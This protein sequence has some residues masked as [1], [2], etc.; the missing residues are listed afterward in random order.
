MARICRILISNFLMTFLRYDPNKRIDTEFQGCKE[1]LSADWTSCGRH[2]P[3][4]SDLYRWFIVPRFLAKSEV[5][6]AQ[7]IWSQI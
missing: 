7:L 4:V 1:S 5:P 2:C 6:K 3:Q